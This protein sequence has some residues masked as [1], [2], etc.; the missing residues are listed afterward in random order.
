[1]A[2][3]RTKTAIAIYL[4]ITTLLAANLAVA[5][6]GSGGSI[7]STQFFTI[8]DTNNYNGLA[9][10]TSI[11]APRAY[12]LAV[13][14]TTTGYSVGLSDF[15]VYGTTTF[16]TPVNTA[17][18]FRILNAATT[19]VF[20]VDTSTGSTTLNRLTVSSTAT[21]SFAGGINITDGCFSINNTCIAGSA[22]VDG[23][24]VANVYAVWSDSNTLTATSS[25][26]FNYFHSTSTATS[27]MQGGL[28][29]PDFMGVRLS[30]SSGRASST[31]DVIGAATLQGGVT[32]TCT[33][34][35][36]DA[37]VVDTLTI[38]SGGSVDSTAL[39]DGGTIGFDWVDDEV[40][41]T[42]TASNL[43]AGSE[44]V[45]D[46]EVSNDITIN[47]SAAITSSAGTSTFIGLV[48]RNVM[49]KDVTLSNLTGTSTVT[50]T[51]GGLLDVNAG[52]F[53]A[54]AS[55]SPTASSTGAFVIDTG[56]GSILYNDGQLG[57]VLVAT[58]SFGA[59]I[60]SSTLRLYGWA[61]GNS[62]GT[63]QKMSYHK[64]IIITNVL[65]DSDNATTTGSNIQLII[66]TGSATSTATQFC[67]KGGQNK[68]HNFGIPANSRFYIELGQ[69]STT[70]PDWT[71]FTISY[72]YAQ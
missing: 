63:I 66:G 41:D 59:N 61:Q 49:L 69:A 67:P 31:F 47:S 25:G 48:G 5:V 36:T 30:F 37:N 26:L 10:S 34:C 54:S 13:A 53:R 1:M 50:I 14:T 8:T 21:S 7:G 55:S 57:N 56:D 6:I 29:V 35:I 42:L 22:A 23:T 51:S 32:I 64:S 71:F 60:S 58:S 43:V 24:G 72:R 27:T 70:V 12:D 2:K 11:Y 3:L 45:A 62:T 20:T 38:S 16:Q 68:V 19:S 9:T 28:T 39:T 44:V 40:S 17:Y 15:V 33:N 46:S 4:T 52:T 65:C 18:A